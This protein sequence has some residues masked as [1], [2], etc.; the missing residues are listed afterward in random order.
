M[1]SPE[2]LT[3]FR[4]LTLSDLSKAPTI[5]QLNLDLSL[6]C[7]YVTKPMQLVIKSSVIYFEFYI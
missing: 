7:M 1:L 3:K 5:E 4:E 6:V 2:E